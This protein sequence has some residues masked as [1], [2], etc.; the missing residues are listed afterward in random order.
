MPAAKPASKHKTK[1]NSFFVRPIYCLPTNQPNCNPP[2][3]PMSHQRNCVCP[4]CNGEFSPK[5]V[6][7]CAAKCRHRFHASCLLQQQ[8]QHQDAKIECPLCKTA[9]GHNHA[10]RDRLSSLDSSEDA[11]WERCFENAL[12]EME[13]ETDNRAPA[14]KRSADDDGDGNG[15]GTS[16]ARSY[17]S[18]WSTAPQRMLLSSAIISKPSPSTT[19]QYHLH[20]Q[21]HH[22]KIHPTTEYIPVAKHSRSTSSSPKWGNWFGSITS[23]AT[24]VHPQ[25]PPQRA[26]PTSWTGVTLPPLKHPSTCS[27]LDM[28]L[29]DYVE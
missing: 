28:E 20:H 14:V 18:S 8:H 10:S 15:K 12:L 26:P 4:F 17:A 29:E 7:M 24:V 1:M 5:T 9:I 25:P 13:E 6:N 21:Y 19:H 11:E 2:R 27:T 22:A 23:S 3:P 16:A